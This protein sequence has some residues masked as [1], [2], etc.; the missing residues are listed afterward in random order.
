MELSPVL[1]AFF[2]G[3]QGQTQ[4]LQAVQGIKDRQAAAEE[5]KAQLAEVVR[6]H[7][8]ENTRADRAYE[9]QASADKAQRALQQWNVT[10]DLQ[11]ML[12]SGALPLAKTA[13]PLEGVPSSGTLPSFGGYGEELFPNVGSGNRAIPI[14]GMGPGASVDPF[15]MMNIPGIGEINVPQP[16]QTERERAGEAAIAQFKAMAPLKTQQEIDVFKATTGVEGD[17]NRNS[18]AVEL[19]KRLDSQITIAGIRADAAREAADAR[20]RSAEHRAT[21]KAEL[22]RLAEFQNLGIPMGETLATHA[23]K[24]LSSFATGDSDIKDVPLNIRGAY[25]NAAAEK[26][27]KLNADKKKLESFYSGPARFDQANQLSEQFKAAIKP[28]DRTIAGRATNWL[29][30]LLGGNSG[31]NVDKSV[32]NAV[33]ANSTVDWEV[34]K[35]LPLGS[36]RTKALFDMVTSTND[37]PGDSPEALQMKAQLRADTILNRMAADVAGLGSKH[38]AIL[39]GKVIEDNPSFVK[40][41]DADT[42]A[43][44]LEAS[45][46]G[47]FKV[48]EW[49]QKLIKKVQNAK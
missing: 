39:Y 16:Q 14:P 34:A 31:L 49:M 20:E 11:E 36:T 42:A 25:Q 23:A 7:N 26:G 48:G 9:L 27:I 19:Q 18:E 29:S 13:I 32:Y 2:Q 24:M 21:V 37:Q 38:R 1:Q 6:Q 5:R 45:R 35:A 40:A 41:L 10:K 30:T 8:L 44:L 4:Q 17:L 22:K 46:T 12:N 33:A 28:T 3:Q 47:E 15:Q 43:R